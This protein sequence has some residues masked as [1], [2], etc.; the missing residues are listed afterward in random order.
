MEEPTL[1][2]RNVRKAEFWKL[3]QMQYPVDIM[4][5]GEKEIEMKRRGSVCAEYMEVST[6][7]IGT[8]CYLKLLVYEV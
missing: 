2:P 5:Y 1:Y 6:L 7:F 4:Q 8:E 3:V